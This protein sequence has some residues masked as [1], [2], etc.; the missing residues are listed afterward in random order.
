MYTLIVYIIVIAEASSQNYTNSSI[1]VRTEL[2]K[3]KKAGI[4]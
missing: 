1:V 4:I 2:C 3:A